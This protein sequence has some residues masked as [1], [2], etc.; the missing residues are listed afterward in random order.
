MSDMPRTHA[1]SQSKPETS[2]APK[3][4]MLLPGL[5]ACS[6]LSVFALSHVAAQVVKKGAAKGAAFAP[7]GSLPVIGTPP[8]GGGGNVPLPVG[9]KVTTERY[10][11]ARAGTNNQETTL[12]PNNLVVSGANKTKSFGKLFTYTVDGLVYGEPLYVQNLPVTNNIGNTTTHNT[13]FV[14]TNNN[15]V[16]AF[17]ADSNTSNNGSP[18]W[19]V[20]FN[21]P[22]SNS[23]ATNGNDVTTV[24]GF[25]QADI[26]PLIGIVGTPVIDETSGTL[27]VVARTT[28]GT[29]YVHRLH[30]IDIRT[31]QEHLDSPALVGQF[32]DPFTGAISPITVPGT[33]DGFDGNGNVAFDTLNQNQ[34]AAL[35]LVNGVV[36]VAY[37]SFDNSPPYHGWVFGY[38]TASLLSRP[39]VFC[40]TPNNVTSNG[41]FPRPT[42][43]G[44]DM[45]GVGM[46]T[47]GSN[48]YFTTG[49]GAIDNG[50]VG[51]GE[52]VQSVLKL[53]FTLTD[54]DPNFAFFQPFN[55]V[56][57]D[58]NVPSLNDAGLDLGTGGVA[59]LDTAI[60]GHSNAMITAGQEGKIY[61]L[62]RNNPG[63]NS[64]QDAG[65]I[66]TLPNVANPA[67]ALLGPSYGAP[68]VYTDNTTA[69]SVT[70]VFFHAAGDVVRGFT[71]DPTA[72]APVPFLRLDARGT[73]ANGQFQ[74]YDFPGAQSSISSTANGANALLWEIQPVQSS[75]P[76]GGNSNQERYA[77]LRAY[78]V[79]RNTDADTLNE[80]Y[81]SNMQASGLDSIGDYIKFSQ[82]MV[83]NGK[84]YVTAGAPSQFNPTPSDPAGSTTFPQGRLVVFGLK[85]VTPNTPIPS[86]GLHYQLSGPVGNVFTIGEV[87]Q[88][89]AYSYSLTALDAN[90]QPQAINGSVN[91]ALTEQGTGRKL[92]LGSATFKN[93]SYIT[94]SKTINSP[95]LFTL[96]AVDSQGNTS[97]YYP[98]IGDIPYVAV[99][100]TI[101]TGFDRFSLRLPTSARSG[102]LTNVTVT[103]VTATGF[104][105]AYQTFVAIYDTIPNG[106]QDYDPFGAN[107]AY[108]FQYGLG[109]SI[110]AGSPIG[111]F[112]DGGFAGTS[113]PNINNSGTYPCIFSGVGQHVVVIQDFFTGQM[114]TGIINIT[115]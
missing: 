101:I 111:I 33:G 27:Y 43:G 62:D 40:T 46:A 112:D 2:R 59:L 107:F 1:G 90:N 52:H 64:A 50:G 99:V 106:A 36:Y 19:H 77:L 12:A 29:N 105:T 26:Q 16:Y 18:L 89:R 95:G 45:A 67:P 39:S 9:L 88:N 103:A 11:N 63:G 71:L 4:R 23:T 92:S 24:F 22:G 56:S 82:P 32:Q 20:N 25:P 109:N 7:P 51:P 78:K 94:F 3:R 13:V 8:I 34:R 6:L 57:Q 70:R 96:Q 37:G 84:V 69:N 86:Q 97:Q 28:E 5:A 93:Q 44:I 21:I 15:S 47:D 30:A 66:L 91:L 100:G 72:I 108:E 79:G 115:P 114:T 113:Y 81:N 14:A 60:P 42:G 41:F 38:P 61:L 104:P 102:Q 10:S 49:L 58:P 31:G 83:A 65:A 48:L 85:T 75:T 80:V 73:D 17:D 74:L 98:L 53:P 35:T 87:E 110:Q 68:T 54:T 55:Y 76:A